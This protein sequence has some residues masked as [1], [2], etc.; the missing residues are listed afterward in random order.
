MKIL[1]LNFN[2]QHANESQ[3]K[4]PHLPSHLFRLSSN[5]NEG[6]EGGEADGRRLG[7]WAGTLLTCHTKIKIY[8]R[9]CVCRVTS[10]HEININVDNI[11]AN[12]PTFKPKPKL[13]HSPGPTRSEA[14]AKTIPVAVAS[15]RD[16]TVEPVKI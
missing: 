2:K 8:Q 9:R 15:F 13:K 10:Q 5:G 1:Y 16:A 3:A 6:G 4:R 12:Q 7:A 11:P 14:Q